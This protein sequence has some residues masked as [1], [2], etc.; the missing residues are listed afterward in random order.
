MFVIFVAAVIGVE[1]SDVL[2]TLPVTPT[3]I[4]PVSL[5]QAKRLQHIV[6]V[7]VACHA[8]NLEAIGR[9]GAIG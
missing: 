9:R 8:R 4:G 5:D 2:A 6:L 1:P 7:R 3:C